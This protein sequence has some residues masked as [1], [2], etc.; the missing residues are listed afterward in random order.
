[1]KYMKIN[2]IVK[3]AFVMAAGILSLTSCEDFLTIYPTDKTVEEDFWKKKADVEQMVTGAYAAVLSGDIQER[4]IM[5]GAFRSDELV[6]TSSHNNTDMDNISIVNLTPVQGICY[7]NSFYK[8][9]NRC[10]IVLNHAPEVVEN[11]P[12]FTEGDYATL[13]AQMLALRS[14]CYFYLVRAFRDVPYTTQSFEN[15]D[16]PREIAQSTP[17][18]VLDSCIASLKDAEAN[19]LKSSAYGYGNWR[20]KGY[21]TRD[22]VQ[23]LLADI[24][25][26]RGSMTKN[27]ADYQECV[28]YADKVIKSKDDY[29]HV[30][31]PVELNMEGKGDIYHL[32]S[33]ESQFNIFGNGNSWESILEWQYDGDKNSNETLERF[34]SRDGDNTTI[35]RVK[36]SAIFNEVDAGAN[37]AGALKVFASTNDYRFW[38]FAF[39]VKSTEASELA[40]RKMVDVYNTFTPINAS[41]GPV[42]TVRNFANYRQNWIVYRLTDVMLM[43]AEAMAQLAADDEDASLEE[44]FNL[45]QVVNKRSMA[46]TASDTLKFENFKGKEKMELLVLAERER[47]LCFEGKRWFDLLRFSYRHMNNV[48]I[49]KLMADNGYV[50]PA[51]YPA[52]LK[53]ISRKFV[54]GGDAVT[55]KMKDERYLYWPI[56]EN[57]LKV[58]PLLKAH[59]VFVSVKTSSKN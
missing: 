50:A 56:H 52:M 2:H 1:M 18:A 39:G 6:K 54:N 47:E 5:W 33:N 26:W 8:V 44:A 14:F 45:V 19:I 20:N 28:K 11:D 31:F 32:Y 34:Y 7:W 13:R 23:A 15:D 49:T 29:Y 48:D 16:T 43:K 10:N 58:N 30:L 9:I 35:P 41:Q 27:A 40:I 51:L 37:G 25:L 24:Y 17:A 12:D 42:Q 57:E 46:R 22:A 55:G 4:A 21:F 38:N 3:T 36:A 53:F 59:P